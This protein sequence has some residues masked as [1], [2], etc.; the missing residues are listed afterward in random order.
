[1]KT[2]QSARE[3]FH[4]S[5]DYIR[6]FR[7]YQLIIL[8]L[9]FFFTAGNFSAQTHREKFVIADALSL[10][11]HDPKVNRHP[12]HKDL[13]TELEIYPFNIG[14]PSDPSV[15]NEAMFDYHLYSDDERFLGG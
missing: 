4:P 10:S 13:E 1:M 2:Q 14:V 6:E 8:S 5:R 9:F 7:K 3:G 12:E 15:K 11:S